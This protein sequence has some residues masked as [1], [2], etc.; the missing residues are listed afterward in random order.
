MG[1]IGYMGL[2]TYS[3]SPPD[4]ACF[5]LAHLFRYVAGILHG[6][7]PMLRKL[8]V[9]AYCQLE[10]ACVFQGFGPFVPVEKGNLPTWQV[11]FTGMLLHT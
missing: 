7:G 5:L 9:A 11:Q 3:L 10:A 2:L 8:A 6:L 1:Y 4:P